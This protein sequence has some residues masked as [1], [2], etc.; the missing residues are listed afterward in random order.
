MQWV[1]KIGGSLYNSKYLIHWLNTISECTDHNIVIVPGGGPFADLVRETDKKFN[2]DQTHAH[3]MA[4]MGMQQYGYLMASMCPR[5]ALASTVDEIRSSWDKGIAVVWEPYQM[6]NRDCDLEKTWQLTSESLAAWLAKFISA[7]GLLFL[8]SAEVALTDV[9]IA[10][11]VGHGCLDHYVP[12]LLV[13][14][15][16]VTCVLHKSQA[17]QLI[18]CL[19]KN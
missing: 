5:L 3:A 8:K 17:K 19:H 4:V 6:V 14:T 16:C 11:L 10:E 2:L 9:S 15:D 18:E 12:E 7:D 13:E 1:I